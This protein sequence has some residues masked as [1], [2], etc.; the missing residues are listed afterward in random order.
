M[1][2]PPEEKIQTSSKD[3]AQL[4]QAELDDTTRALKEITFNVG[5]KPCGIGQIDPT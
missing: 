2:L 5:T 4:I 3:P 1:A